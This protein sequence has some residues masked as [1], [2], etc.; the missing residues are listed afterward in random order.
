MEQTAVRAYEQ[1]MRA[2]NGVSS[3]AGTIYNCPSGQHDDLAISCAMLVWA[4]QHPHLAYWCV[5]VG[6]ASPVRSKRQ[7]RR[8]A[9]GWT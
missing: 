5:G 6:A 7:L 1:L 8:S 9:L 4:A 3:R 2:G